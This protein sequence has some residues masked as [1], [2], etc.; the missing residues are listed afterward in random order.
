[1]SEQQ[2]PPYRLMIWGLGRIYYRMF[3]RLQ[4]LIRSGQMRVAAVTSGDALPIVSVDGFPDVG[5]I[6]DYTIS[7]EIRKD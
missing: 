7:I 5:A 1:M 3:N 6:G 4:D 2:H